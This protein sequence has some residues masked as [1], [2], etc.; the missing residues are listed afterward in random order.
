MEKKNMDHLGLITG[1]GN[2]MELAVNQV[3]IIRMVGIWT[4]M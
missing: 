1:A 2:A 3:T 4:I